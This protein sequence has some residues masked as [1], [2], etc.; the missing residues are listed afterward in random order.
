MHSI[1]FKSIEELYRADNWNYD[2]KRENPMATSASTSENS[3][4][5]IHVH[6]NIALFLY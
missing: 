2:N 3:W 1:L 6:Y 5:V 4:E